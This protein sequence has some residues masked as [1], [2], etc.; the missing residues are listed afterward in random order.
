MFATALEKCNHLRYNA[1][2]GDAGCIRN[3]IVS[4]LTTVSTKGRGCCTTPKT[5][6]ELSTTEEVEESSFL[7]QNIF[8]MKTLQQGEYISIQQGCQQLKR[9][10][11]SSSVS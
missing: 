3:G 5:K 2:V 8:E 10:I 9:T 7:L 4:I 11:G 6:K 1:T